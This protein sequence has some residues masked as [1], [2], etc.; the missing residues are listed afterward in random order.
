MVR[1]LTGRWWDITMLAAGRAILNRCQK[2]VALASACCLWPP[3]WPVS[4]LSWFLLWPCCTSAP[5]FAPYHPIPWPSLAK[6][7]SHKSTQ[8]YTSTPACKIHIRSLDTPDFGSLALWSLLSRHVVTPSGSC[9]LPIS[10]LSQGKAF[11]TILERSWRKVWESDLQS[12][13]RSVRTVQD[14]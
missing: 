11:K 4:S 14:L 13:Q 5:I 2:R 3:L 10:G 12:E 8:E 7:S 1:V 6:S 9:A